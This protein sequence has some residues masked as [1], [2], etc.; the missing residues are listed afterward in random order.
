MCSN[1]FIVVAIDIARRRHLSP[2]NGR[3]PGLQILWGRRD[4]SEMISRHRV[5]A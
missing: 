5:T 1:I 4:A 3:V 2:C